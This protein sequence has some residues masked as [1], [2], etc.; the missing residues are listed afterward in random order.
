MLKD[1][2]KYKYNRRCQNAAEL[3]AARRQAE[4]EKERE[5]RRHQDAQAKAATRQ[6]ASVRK[7]E[8]EARAA[9]RRSASV[10]Q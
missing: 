5:D 8:A 6:S 9:K 1:L 7:K 2:F 3:N 10:R 4:T